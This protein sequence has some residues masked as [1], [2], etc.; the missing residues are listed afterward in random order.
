MLTDADM[1]SALRAFIQTH[2]SL[3]LSTGPISLVDEGVFTSVQRT[4]TLLPLSYH[5]RHANAS[6][7]ELRGRW[8]YP[9]MMMNDCCPREPD[10]PA[11]IVKDACGGVIVRLRPETADEV[12]R[13]LEHDVFDVANFQTRIEGRAREARLKT[14]EVQRRTFL[15]Q[16]RMALDAQLKTTIQAAVERFS[17]EIR[18]L[19]RRLVEHLNTHEFQVHSDVDE[20]RTVSALCAYGPTGCAAVAREVERSVCAALVLEAEE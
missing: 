3:P 11:I 19:A 14:L 7:L 16:K 5:G 20:Y 10:P 15:I 17:G 18:T 8:S 4:R 13:M 9:V 6:L 1:H 12:A 2:H